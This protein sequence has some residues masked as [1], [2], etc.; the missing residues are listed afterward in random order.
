MEPNPIEYTAKLLP[1]STSER[2][3]Y[4]HPQK[5]V[6]S[7]DSAVTKA[8]KYERHGATEDSEETPSKRVKLD[9]GAEHD[10]NEELPIKTERQKG[11]APIKAESVSAI[12]A[13]IDSVFTIA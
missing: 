11:V 10:G 7:T 3:Q 9:L 8:E 1:E 13:E 6:E 12:R 5:S 4:V 2:E